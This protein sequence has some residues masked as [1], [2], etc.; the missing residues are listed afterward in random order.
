[1]LQGKYN[2]MK[3]VLSDL[4]KNKTINDKKKIKIV[5]SY[6]SNN[7][8]NKTIIDLLF[9]RIKIIRKLNKYPF[10]EDSHRD[11]LSNN[12]SKVNS[13]TSSLLIEHAK[14]LEPQKQESVYEL[15]KEI[16]NNSFTDKYFIITQKNIE[17]QKQ[18][19]EIKLENTGLFL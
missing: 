1:M 13:E 19:N 5:L 16:Q 18:K 14:D 9:K 6:F 8:L 3:E 11:T 10:I 4:D 2:S 12:L 15:A 17:K 7:D